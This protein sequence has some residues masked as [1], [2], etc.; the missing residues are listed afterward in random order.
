[1][2]GTPFNSKENPFI[3]PV[4]ATFGRAVA[5]AASIRSMKSKTLP[6]SDSAASTISCKTIRGGASSVRIDRSTSCRVG[7]FFGEGASRPF[8]LVKS[9]FS[10]SSCVSAMAR[11]A[12]NRPCQSPPSRL[13]RLATMW[14]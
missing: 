2:N 1:L 10:S 12:S 3:R 8:V 11:F 13:I 4:V 6:G 9:C 14:M 7:A 5:P